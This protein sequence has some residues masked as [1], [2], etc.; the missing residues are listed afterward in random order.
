MRATFLE[1]TLRAR[2]EAAYRF[3]TA[4]AGN[5]PGF[6]EAIRAL[7]EIVL[8]LRDGSELAGGR[9]GICAASGLDK[10]LLT[11]SGTST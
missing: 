5:L 11:G 2:R 8:P 9:A 7:F 1:G 10:P 4:M 3:M 6:E